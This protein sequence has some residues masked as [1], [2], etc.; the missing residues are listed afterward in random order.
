MSP[1]EVAGP[2]DG[3]A[4]VELCG[5]EGAMAGKLLA[6]MGADVIKVEPPAGDASRR[7]EPFL[8][9]EPGVER[10]LH[11]WHYNT[12]KRGITLDIEQEA[13][14]DVVRRLIARSDMFIES[15]GPGRAAA[16]GLGYDELSDGHP[17]LIMASLS[18]FGQSGPRSEEQATDLTIL[19]GG[20]PAWS[21]GYDDHSLPPVRGGGN[22]GYQTGCHFL[23][24]SVLVALLHRD[25]TGR[26][27]YIDI[28][29]HAAANVTTEAAS[30]S[31]L[32]AE[33][34]V[35]RQTGRHAGVNPSMPT[36]VRCADGRY[37]NTGVPPRR[38]GDFRRLKDWLVEAGLA[39]EFPETAILEV[40]A[41]RERIDLARISEDPEVAAVF[42]AGREATNF[43]ASR[44]GA[45]EFFTAAQQRG[46]QVGIIYSPE[47][48]LQDP[49]LI[50]RG[51]PTEV[52]HPELGRSFVY[53]GAPYKFERSPWK[54]S[55]APLL[56]EHNDDVYRA[57]GLSEA[58][59]RQLRTDG[60]V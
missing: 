18:P 21:C 58:E 56:G 55:R 30:Y 13:G 9:D 10:S 48:V 50:E 24:M 5:E 14:S 36:Q 7:Y 60:A 15:L 47:E 42:S 29:M 6:D 27:Q 59:V 33:E 23:V 1:E 53:A 8:D 54:V 4:V 28:N 41:L 37:V 22:Q 46:F 44:L 11:F 38:P 39:D 20:G 19:A 32:V 35:Q 45:F 12:S 17:E 3:L 26:G 31:W 25:N 51:F 43:L 57:L 40:G 16:L 52:E 34:T 49:H 2:L